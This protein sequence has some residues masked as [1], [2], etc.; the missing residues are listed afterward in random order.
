M[1]KV[2]VS[3][4]L[5]INTIIGFS[6]VENS[7][8]DSKVRIVFNVGSNY[9]ILQSKENLPNNTEIN[10]GIG[11]SCG[12]LM[13]YSLSQN[14]LF[15]PKIELAFHNNEVKTVN[16]DNSITTYSV[17]PIS[18]NVMTHFIYKIGEG[19]TIPYVL[20]GPNYKLPIKDNSKSN[21][22]LNS[23]P[24]FA[25][26]LGIGLENKLKYFI[27]APELRYSYGLLNVNNNPSLQSLNYQS[28]SL[29]CNFK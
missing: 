9:S 7:N 5:V 23:K 3:F 28:I 4:V 21:N 24:D 22:E 8:V 19:K 2:V 18:F 11:F 1:K 26:D 17:L 14:V 10:N 27:F 25:I 29:V 15:S 20:V 16:N 6:Q 13:D 12:L